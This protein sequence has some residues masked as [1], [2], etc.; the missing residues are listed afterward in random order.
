MAALVGIANMTIH[1]THPSFRW[2][3]V[4][5]AGLSAI[6]VLGAT[7]QTIPWLEWSPLRWL[8]RISY[9]L[10]LWHGVLIWLP[11]DLLPLRPLF[12]QAIM[13][14]LV[15]AASWHFL[16]KRWLQRGNTAAGDGTTGLSRK[17]ERAGTD[18]E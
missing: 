11:W 1:F 13:P 15:A 3:V 5:I 2:G 16:E 14:L 8:G 6:A 12:W 9:G 17:P 18:N 4:P 10:Y 7:S